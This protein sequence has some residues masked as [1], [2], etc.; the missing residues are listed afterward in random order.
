M[1]L[2]PDVVNCDVLYGRTF[3]LVG[4]DAD[5]VRRLFALQDVLRIDGEIGADLTDGNVIGHKDVSVHV[6]SMLMLQ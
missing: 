3:P 6:M 2:I 5:S 1:P 4:E